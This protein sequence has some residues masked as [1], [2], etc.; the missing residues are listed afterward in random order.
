MV[1]N[2]KKSYWADSLV[3]FARM[4]GWVAGPIIVGLFL[5]KWL[6]RMFGTAPMIFIIT[7]T[8]SF[9]V[10][11]FGIVREAKRYM[12]ALEKQINLEKIEHE[13]NSNNNS[14]N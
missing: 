13:R 7:I 1:E 11:T 12:K 2:N 14:T 8:F 3:I 4:S 9:L 10:S 5:G 6:D